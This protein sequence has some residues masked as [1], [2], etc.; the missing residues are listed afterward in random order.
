MIT[1]LQN[2]EHT[3]SL[4]A[5]YHKLILNESKNASFILSILEI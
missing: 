5:V 2:I 4:T 1:I 3:Y